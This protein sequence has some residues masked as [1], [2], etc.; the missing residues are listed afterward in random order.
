MPVDLICCLSTRITIHVT[1]CHILRDVMLRHVTFHFV[2]RYAMQM[3]VWL[4]CFLSCYPTLCYTLFCC[5]KLSCIFVYLCYS[6]CVALP[7]FCV[8]FVYN[9][10]DM[11]NAL[12]TAALCHAILC[13]AVLCYAILCFIITWCAILWYTMPCYVR[14]CYTML[15]YDMSCYIILCNTMLNTMLNAMLNAMLN[16]ML[17]C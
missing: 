15:G 13:C 16:T 12:C 2:L 11:L 3:Y 4:D 6:F 10:L 8:I 7:R 14:L 1:F 9:M 17:L 5:A